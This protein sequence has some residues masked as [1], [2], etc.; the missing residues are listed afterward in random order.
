MTKTTKGSPN[1]IKVMEYKAGEQYNLPENLYHVFKKIGACQ[2]VEVK[3]VSNAPQNKMAQVPENKVEKVEEI[4]EIEQ[5]DIQEVEDKQ[6]YKR[7]RR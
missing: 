5:E 3:A 2:D 4:P 6:S 7:R 1:G